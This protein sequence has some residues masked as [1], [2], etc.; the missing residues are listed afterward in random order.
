MEYANME[1]RCYTPIFV[2]CLIG[3]VY[4]PSIFTCL[5]KSIYHKQKILLTPISE[6]NNFTPLYC[7]QEP[8]Q[9]A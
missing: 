2:Q 7:L 6:H 9:G 8:S 5:L 4:T 3:I 1:L